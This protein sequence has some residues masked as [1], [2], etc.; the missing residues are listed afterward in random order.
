[1][2]G[3]HWYATYLLAVHRHPEALDQI[4]QARRLDP[5]ST[6][7]LADKG[8]L[9]WCA[10][11]RSEGLALLKQLEATQPS[12]SSTHAYLGRIYWERKEY[13]NAL[14]E[15]RQVAELRH[16]PAG[17]A[18]AS[19][20]E[21]GFAVGGLKGM[22]ES[23]LP[24]R[25]DLFSHGSGSAY[26][27]AETYAALGQKQEALAYLQIAFDQREGFMLTG[28]P[29]IPSLRDEPEYRKLENQVQELLAK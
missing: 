16:H 25:K 14:T 24:V 15:W 19:A 13:P 20:R 11:Q 2:R 3:H 21:K 26:E 7:I 22:Y 4:E 27:L 5:S 6:A 10:G 29:A 9:L 17:L 18:I 1:M 28:D 8:F 23:E 12:L